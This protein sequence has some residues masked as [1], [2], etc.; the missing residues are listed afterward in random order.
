MIIGRIT[1][2]RLV[3]NSLNLEDINWIIFG[4]YSQD[5]A[6]HSPNSVNI[7]RIQSIKHQ[8][9][10]IMHRIRWIFTE[11]EHSFTNLTWPN[12]VFFRS[13]WL[14]LNFHSSE[15][16]GII[17]FVERVCNGNYDLSKSNQ[18]KIHQRGFVRHADF[19]TAS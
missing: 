12:L 13:I 4:E 2:H 7:H 5:S 14:T 15:I 19:S 3:N 11:N 16:R 17:F 1:F 9:W 6:Y 10:S 8:I 18:W